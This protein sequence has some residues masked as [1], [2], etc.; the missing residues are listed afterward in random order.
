MNQAPQN[1]ATVLKIMRF[2]TPFRFSFF[3]LSGF[4][5]RRAGNLFFDLR[6]K[7]VLLMT[8]G[9]IKESIRRCMG[10]QDHEWLT[11]TTVWKEGL[12]SCVVISASRDPEG[13]C[14]SRGFK[15]KY[16][17]SSNSSPSH[18]HKVCDQVLS[19]MYIWVPSS[20][21]WTRPDSDRSYS[22]VPPELCHWW[23]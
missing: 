2:K 9:G 8:W 11:T 10:R 15:W 12:P 13:T 20:L 19:C 1:H 3:F 23:Q 5:T 21:Q 16:C 14:H 4:W 17:G 22:S 18:Y 7:V 6:A